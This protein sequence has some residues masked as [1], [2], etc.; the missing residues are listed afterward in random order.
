MCD[1]HCFP[2][3]TLCVVSSQLSPFKQVSS[4]Y[5]SV[6]GHKTLFPG[7]DPSA[8]ARVERCALLCVTPAWRIDSTLES[9]ISHEYKLFPENWFTGSHQK[10]PLLPLGVT[11]LAAD[12]ECREHI[13]RWCWDTTGGETVDFNQQEVQKG[14]C[15]CVSKETGL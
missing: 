7:D 13:R 9:N 5:K 15:L 4:F 12:K 8:P 3:C 1:L 10:L 11:L 2:C 14:G 6:N